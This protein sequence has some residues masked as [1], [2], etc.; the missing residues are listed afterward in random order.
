MEEAA[1]Q[2]LLHQ[3][4]AQGEGS[5]QDHHA[6]GHRPAALLNRNQGTGQGGAV[7]DGEPLDQGAVK[8]QEGQRDHH[9]ARQAHEC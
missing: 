2:D 7:Q 4:P 1:E 6:G 8:V 3:V 5:Q 9:D